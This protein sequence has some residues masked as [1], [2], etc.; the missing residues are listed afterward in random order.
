MGRC[1]EKQSLIISTSLLQLSR[2]VIG[3]AVTEQRIIVFDL[4]TVPDLGVGRLLLSED[5]AA[6]D[7]DVRGRLGAR[8]AKQGEVPNSVFVKVPLQKI[9]C[10]GALYAQRSSRAAEW[11]I[12][13]AGVGHIGLRTER[14]L[15]ENF[16]FSFQ[17][18]P[19]PQLVGF[20]SS[21]F[22]LPVLRCRALALSV[23][24]P[25]L[26][27]SNGRDYWYRFGRDH[28]DLCDVLSNFGASP[29]P[30]LNEL[31]A[32]CGIPQKPD[33]IEG[34]RVEAFVNS[35]RIEDVA[36]YCEI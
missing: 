23:A 13:R 31:A 32:L 33:G 36:N 3:G 19:A 4:E 8:Y 5:D 6:A 25:E 18:R 17:D 29:R 21:S 16:V 26:H 28:I 35:N 30:S 12:T 1:L 2:W 15:L 14:Q 7:A 22:D 24:A 11:N 27:R 20:N 10:I 34:S 9:V